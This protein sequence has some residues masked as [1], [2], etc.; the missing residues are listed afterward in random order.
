MGF[1]CS[2]SC[3]PRLLSLALER[4]PVQISYWAVRSQDAAL[5]GTALEYLENVLPEAVRTALWPHLGVRARPARSARPAQ[6]VVEE[7]MRSSNTLAFSRELL[8][9]KLPRS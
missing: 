9:R 7:L 6:Q 8:K 2:G 4:E 5:R 3:V 1:I